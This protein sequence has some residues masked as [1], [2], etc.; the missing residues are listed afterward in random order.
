MNTETINSEVEPLDF[1]E[2][3]SLGNVM[4]TNQCMNFVNAFV[5]DRAKNNFVADYSETIAR[6]F[7]KL[8]NF[9]TVNLYMLTKVYV[10]TIKNAYDRYTQETYSTFWNGFC[11]IQKKLL[12][13]FESFPITISIAVSGCETKFLDNVNCVVSYYNPKSWRL[14]YGS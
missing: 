13:R 9:L 7:E 3:Q 5:C 6:A 4:H 14:V 1:L 11:F 2:P 10:I 8:Y 12:S